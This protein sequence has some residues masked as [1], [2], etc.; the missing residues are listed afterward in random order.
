MEKKILSFTL[1]MLFLCF[2]IYSNANAAVVEWSQLPLIGQSGY[3]FSSEIQVPSAVA[4]DFLCQNG[5]P[6]IG[7]T[8]WGS[9]WNPTG[10]VD[11]QVVSFYPYPNS[12]TW[13]DPVPNPPGTVS[14]FIISFWSDI[15]TGQGIPPWSY[16]GTLLYAV[17]IPLDGIQITE[18]PFGSINHGAGV[19]ETVFQYN[20]VLPMALPQEAGQIY[21]LSIQ[22]VDHNGNPIQWGWH[23]SIN[24]WNDNAVQ[25]GFP[26][27][28]LQ[29]GWWHLMP[30]EDMAFEIQAV[31][32]P[33]TLLLVA[34]GLL[35][36][37]GL[38]R[39]LR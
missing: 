35:G 24:H 2:G 10:L 14:G 5:L 4:D 20:A 26:P 11:G 8:W 22:A 29:P 1:L 9:Y 31:P 34:T 3:N 39:R 13:G 32:I 15:P 27:G 6:I 19:I 12:D 18:T 17:T 16:P 33:G 23:E 21:W 38:R 37:L 30:G 36:I 7:V 28:G 25:M